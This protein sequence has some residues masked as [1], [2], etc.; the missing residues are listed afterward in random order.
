MRDKSTLRNI[1]NS[2][3]SDYPN[4]RI[5]DNTGAGN[6]TPVNEFMYGD[7]HEMI[8]KLMRLAGIPFNGLP[9]NESNGYQTVDAL[10]ALASKNDYLIEVTASGTTINLPLRLSRLKLNESFVGKVNFSKTN[11]TTVKGTLDNQ[12]KPAT[13]DGDFE[14]GEYVRIIS[15]SGS[16]QFIRMVDFSSLNKMSASLGFLK[17]STGAQVIA[18]ILDSVGVTPESFLEAF[19]EYTIGDESNNFLASIN[20]NGLMSEEDKNKLDSL[21]NS[22][23]RNIGYL[24]GID[25]GGGQT[26]ASYAVSG[27]VASALIT[28]EGGGNI[29]IRVT[30]KNAMDNSDYYVRLHAQSLGN[31]DYDVQNPMFKVINTTTFD[32]RWAETQ[33]VDQ[34]IKLHIEAVQI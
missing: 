20:R 3:P 5:Q 19:A 12:S 33:G 22:S 31:R 15:L 9:D 10:I 16:I 28:Q 29:T 1:N 18:G 32:V 17:K 8:A 24:S 30:M 11:Q 34:N 25:I 4:G 23:V 6:G 26:G 21:G 27:D 2:N 13:F 7:I 14:S